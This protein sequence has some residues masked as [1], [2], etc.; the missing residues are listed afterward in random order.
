MRI[1][2]LRVDARSLA[3]G[4]RHV[5]DVGPWIQMRLPLNPALAAKLQQAIPF[6]PKSTGRA[7]TLKTEFH[8]RRV[9]LNPCA[10][11]ETGRRLKLSIVLVRVRSMHVNDSGPEGF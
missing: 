10:D 2:G 4:A 6:A 8:R 5:L 11:H 1:G 9:V 3:A 7:N